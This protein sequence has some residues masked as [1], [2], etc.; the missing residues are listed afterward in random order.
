MISEM[1]PNSYSLPFL[2]EAT[3]CIHE[4]NGEAFWT[5]DE[6]ADGITAEKGTGGYEIKF[7]LGRR[8]TKKSHDVT[9]SCVQLKL[10][11]LA[12]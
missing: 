8:V 11:G 6:W 9:E 7:L 5:D 10:S 3:L 12:R 1:T 2:S 4:Q